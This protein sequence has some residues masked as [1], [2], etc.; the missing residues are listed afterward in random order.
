MVMTRG[1]T[2]QSFTTIEH[3]SK[4]FHENVLYTH[5]KNPQTQYFTKWTFRRFGCVGLNRVWSKGKP[6][7]V[8]ELFDPTGS[9]SYQQ[10]GLF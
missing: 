7:Q 6:S 2:F 10:K 5:P 1:E 4:S 9:L 3:A 8:A